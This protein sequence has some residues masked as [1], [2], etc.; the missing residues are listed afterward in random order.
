[1]TSPRTHVRVGA[2]VLAALAL[3][4]VVLVTF[5]GLHLLEQRDHY[6][7]E[8]RDSVIGL[9]SGATVTF[10]GIAVGRVDSI[11]VS[12][13]DLGAVRVT[14]SVKAGTPV[15]TDTVAF[16]TLAGLTG[17]KTV[18]LRGG[19]LATARMPEGG[20]LAAGQ[21]TLDKLEHH[22][23]QLADQSI[24]LM[25]RAQLIVAA[26]QRVTENLEK[27]TDPRPVASIVAQVQ[28]ATRTLAAAS[29]SIAAM[30]DEDR[31]AIRG[32]LGSLDAAAQSARDVLANQ[33]GELAT[34]ANQLVGE[35]RGVVRGN[36]GEVRAAMAD[37]RQASQ[38]FEELAREVR[39]RPS[40]LLFSPAP[41]DRKLP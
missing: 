15:H 12:P 20:T 24:E 31:V 8:M 33:I 11:D 35:L 32:T 9:E 40:R 16:L 27:I 21:S 28:D 29:R 26:A 4:A 14:L 6:V 36:A 22:A 3:G 5:G 7:V 17:L 10:D 38:S 23:D 30:V 1:V 34:N 13:T 41:H 39:D 19:S 37:L 18:D 2:F 25:K